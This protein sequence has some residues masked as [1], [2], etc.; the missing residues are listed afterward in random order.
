[1][2]NFFDGVAESKD[3]NFIGRFILSAGSSSGTTSDLFY[4]KEFIILG[5]K[6]KMGGESNSLLIKLEGFICGTLSK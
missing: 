5:V 3:G 1:M 6:K 4:F 2:A